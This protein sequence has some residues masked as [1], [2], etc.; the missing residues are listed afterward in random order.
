MITNKN[1]IINN[2]DKFI[3][4]FIIFIITTVAIIIIIIIMINDN[5]NMNDYD[6]LCEYE[7]C[8]YNFY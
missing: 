7:L 2:I 1:H 3:I 4:A 8:Y 5:G 6:N